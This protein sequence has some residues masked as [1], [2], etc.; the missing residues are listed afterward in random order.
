MAVEVLSPVVAVELEDWVAWAGC[1]DICELDPRRSLWDGWTYYTKIKCVVGKRTNF[2]QL[3]P[4][5]VYYLLKRAAS[6]KL[7]EQGLCRLYSVTYHGVTVVRVTT[8]RQYSTFTID[9]NN[10]TEAVSLGVTGRVVGIDFSYS[11]LRIWIALVGALPG[12]VLT[13]MFEP[14]SLR[15]V[16]GCVVLWA[17]DH[18]ISSADLL[19]SMVADQTTRN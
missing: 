4:T 3:S 13:P 14:P 18:T 2:N 7:D 9:S 16:A 6:M 15:C 11:S 10:P 12:D 8:Q 17:P 1:D 5:V 19:R